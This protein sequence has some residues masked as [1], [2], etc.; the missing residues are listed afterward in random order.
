MQT[1]VVTFDVSGFLREGADA[2]GGLT[3]NRE[4]RRTRLRSALQTEALD[5]EN[6]AFM[7]MFNRAFRP[8]SQSVGRIKG[9]FGH[10]FPTL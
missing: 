9:S 8:F 2:V 7:Q 5:G 4:A 10:F 6:N 1:F 3:L